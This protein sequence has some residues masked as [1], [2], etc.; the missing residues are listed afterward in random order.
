MVKHR[1]GRIAGGRKTLDDPLTLAQSLLDRRIR[2][3]ASDEAG[4]R[5]MLCRQ[6]RLQRNNV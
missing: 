3:C 1:S 4:R 2:V 6:T 5:T